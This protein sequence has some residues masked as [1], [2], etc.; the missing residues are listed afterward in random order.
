[1]YHSRCKSIKINNKG[2]KDEGNIFTLQSSSFLSLS[3]PLWLNYV[4]NSFVHDMKL[5]FISFYDHYN[6]FS[7]KT[8]VPIFKDL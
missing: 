7:V 2:T 1:M 3:I 6:L 5:K 4:L 8:N